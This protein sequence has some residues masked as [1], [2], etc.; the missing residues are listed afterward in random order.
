M[1]DQT[2]INVRKVSVKESR[3]KILSHVAFGKG[4]FIEQ[5]HIFVE[6]WWITNA[7][8]DFNYTYVVDMNRLRN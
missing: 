1:N 7:I 8:K 2:Y 6:V 4:V 3:K 5:L